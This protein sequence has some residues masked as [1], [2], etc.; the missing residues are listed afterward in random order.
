MEIFEDK[1]FVK[2]LNNDLKNGEIVCFVTDTVWGVGCL[3]SSKEGAE[4]I[5]STKGRDRSKPLIL[6]SNDIDN[7]VPYTK[8]MSDTAKK[9]AG[10]FFPGAL[11][12]ISEK[13]DLTHD[14]VSAGKNTIG[15]RVPN[16][17]FFAKLCSVIEGG[18]LATTSANPS[19][20]ESA[21]NFEQAKKYLEG[22]VKYIFPDYGF[23]CAGMESTVVLALDENVKVLRQGAV[24][25]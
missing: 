20:V 16:N 15:I 10:K 7:L 21:K 22:S 12:I 1:N 23:E 5:Y 2:K 4:K 6:M 8:N 11:T 13:S 3:P 25:I 17:E 14:W 18:V 24:K 19:S 9:L